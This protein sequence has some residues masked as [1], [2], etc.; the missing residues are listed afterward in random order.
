[1]LIMGVL[2]VSVIFN[3]IVCINNGD[4]D[5]YLMEAGAS[6]FKISKYKIHSCIQCT[7]DFKTF[8]DSHFQKNL[9]LSTTRKI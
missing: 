6:D 1:M 9:C 2:V 5:F 7:D 4:Y 8:S 3:V